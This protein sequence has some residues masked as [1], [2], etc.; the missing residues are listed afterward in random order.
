MTGQSTKSNSVE[1]LN[2]PDQLPM[3]CVLVS[4]VETP[5]FGEWLLEPSVPEPAPQPFTVAQGF[6]AVCEK[7]VVSVP[8]VLFPASKVNPP[9]VALG[10]ISKLKLA[11]VI[12]KPLNWKEISLPGVP[13]L[14]LL[15]F[16]LA[17]NWLEKPWVVSWLYVYCELLDI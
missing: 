9:G 7:M 1:P 11:P 16:V 17:R 12:V 5:L 2:D 3:Y 10:K 15:S 13:R 14:P 4:A 6:N 8:L